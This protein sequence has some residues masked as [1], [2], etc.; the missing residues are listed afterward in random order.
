MSII[1]MLGSLFGCQAQNSQDFRSVEVSEFEQVIADTAVVLVDVRTPEEYAEGH[2]AGAQNI[3][4][5]D[6]AFEKTA[7]RVLPKDRTIAV[8]C[9]SGRRS[10]MAAGIL[11]AQGYTIVEL[12]TGYLGWT[13][14]GKEVTSHKAEVE[15]TKQ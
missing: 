10:K 2:I 13:G 5:K 11:A 12:N 14:A 7:C 3:D 9:R 15:V 8:Y 1:A 4:V 6:A